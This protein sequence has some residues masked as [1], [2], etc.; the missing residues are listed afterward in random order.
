MV[1]FGDRRNE[2]SR[3]LANIMSDLPLFVGGNNAGSICIL[4]QVAVDPM[5]GEP[6]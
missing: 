4:R 1:T 3:M 5:C 6:M 2:R